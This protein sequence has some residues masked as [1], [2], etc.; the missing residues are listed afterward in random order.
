MKPQ[1]TSCNGVASRQPLLLVNQPHRSSHFLFTAS[2]Q[3]LDECTCCMLLQQI[4]RQCNTQCQYWHHKYINSMRKPW[5]STAIKCMYKWLK[6]DSF[7]SCSSSGTRLQRNIKHCGA[8]MPCP[9]KP[10]W[11]YTGKLPYEHAKFVTAK[12]SRGNHKHQQEDLSATWLVYI[13][14]IPCTVGVYALAVSHNLHH[15]SCPV[16][17]QH[18][19]HTEQCTTGRQ[20]YIDIQY[21]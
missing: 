14:T 21:V 11:N 18:Y 5:H 16:I 2:N 8:S 15:R 6:P 13:T 7:Y 4:Y 17:L 10:N 9:A 12:D 3:P 1:V 20:M 19:R